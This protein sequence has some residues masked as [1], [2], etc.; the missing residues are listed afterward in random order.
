M[1]EEKTPEEYGAEGGRKRAANRTKAEL[2]E[3]GKKGALARWGNDLP[4][5]QYPG[6]LQL[7]DTSF[8]CAVLSDG[9]RVLT[10]MDF[11]KGMEMYRSGAL[12]V[13]RGNERGAREPLFLAFKNLK[14]FIDK[15]LGDVHTLP[16]RTLNGNVAYGI[17]AEIIVK[18]CDIW[19][20]A[21][22]AGVLGQRQK[23]VAEQARRLKTALANKAL[24]DLVDEATGYKQ[25]R[26]RDHEAE[27]IDKFVAK[28]L[29]PW[30]STFPP[31]FYSELYR[32]KNWNYENM[33]PNSPKPIEVG[34][35]TDDLV[36]KRLAPYVRDEL[37][38]L[39]PRSDK[40]YLKNKLHSLLTPDV[41]N[42]KLKEHF[43]M[44]LAIMAGHTGF[45]AFQH[46]V[47]LAL[48]RYDKTLPLALYDAPRKPLQLELP[49]D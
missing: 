32:L 2:S 24:I 14:P 44:L 35:L 12:S 3:I 10:E 28:E 16:F 40:G 4:V 49:A 29:R 39:T 7:G 43:K 13:R 41:G 11:M 8:P 17:R 6:V 47:N 46:H 18:I 9:T 26:R 30:V 22:A 19:I 37:R 42:P 25:S 48:P 1:A 27:I 15:H 33:R 31:E 36:Y 34:R 38:R 21:D 45:D 5:A 23:R 20:D